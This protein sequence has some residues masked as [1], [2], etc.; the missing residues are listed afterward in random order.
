MAVN[1]LNVAERDNLKSIEI[2]ERTNSARKGEHGALDY[3]NT[4][5]M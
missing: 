5:C 2:C 1:E 3:I 4:T